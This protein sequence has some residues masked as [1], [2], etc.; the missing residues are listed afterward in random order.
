MMT[1]AT[2]TFHVILGLAAGSVLAAAHGLATR[3]AANAALERG[4]AAR[5]LLGFPVRVG[6]PALAL[7]G[8][9]RVSIW[10]LAGGMLAFLVGQRLLL[11]RLEHPAPA[12]GEE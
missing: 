7:F 11:A 1:P 2:A 12:A 8:L 10:A 4:S 3:R 5:L 9:A 6:V